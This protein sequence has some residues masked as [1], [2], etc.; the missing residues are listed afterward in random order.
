MEGL[1]RV[2]LSL[3]LGLGLGLSL[4]LSFAAGAVSVLLGQRLRPR[5]FEPKAT[6]D[7]KANGR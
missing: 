2:S 3:S 4:S 5:L 6:K 7:R 1:S